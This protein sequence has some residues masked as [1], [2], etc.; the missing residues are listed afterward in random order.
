MAPRL[1]ASA[2]SMCRE[3]SPCWWH[4]S[5]TRGKV[6]QGT[7]TPHAVMVTQQRED[8]FKAAW[9]LEKF[10]LQQRVKEPAVDKLAF[11]VQN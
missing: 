9:W 4:C 7:C 5:G 11:F 8:D 2:L 3:G 10:L 1:R 6:Q